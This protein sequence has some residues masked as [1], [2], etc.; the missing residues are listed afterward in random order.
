MVLGPDQ[1]SEQWVKVVANELG[2]D[3]SVASKIRR[4]DR[5]VT[6][7]VDNMINFDGRHILIVDDIIS[8]GMTVLKAAQAAQERGARSIHAA[9]TH[10][11]FTWETEAML[12]HMGIRQIISCDGVPHSTN[13]IPLAPIIAK[14]LAS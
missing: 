3:Y 4:G 1:E 6:V 12:K 9:V 11:L 8:S 5:D 2:L 14:A 7:C 13:K 10:A